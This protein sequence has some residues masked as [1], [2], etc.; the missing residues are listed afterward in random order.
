MLHGNMYHGYMFHIV[1]DIVHAAANHDDEAKENLYQHY[2]I[3]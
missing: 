2:T 3:M 1:D